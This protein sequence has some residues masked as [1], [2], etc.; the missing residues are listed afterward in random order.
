M[1]GFI[2]HGIYSRECLKAMLIIKG[3]CIMVSAKPQYKYETWVHRK[4]CV[5]V[6][7]EALL[8]ISPNYNLNVYQQMNGYTKCDIFI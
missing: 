7:K 3:M 2:F 1:E 6:F 5:W 4:T 8:I